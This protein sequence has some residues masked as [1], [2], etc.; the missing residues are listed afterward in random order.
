MARCLCHNLAS[1]KIWAGR[2]E[3]YQPRLD[4]FDQSKTHVADFGHRALCC[5]RKC[6]FMLEALLGNTVTNSADRV[7]SVSMIGES[8]SS[9]MSMVS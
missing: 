7:M 9:M 6:I 2:R 4:W 5:H 3:D 8:I 1:V